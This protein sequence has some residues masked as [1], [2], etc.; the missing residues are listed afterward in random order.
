M[1]KSLDLFWAGTASHAKNEQWFWEVDC[2][3]FRHSAH[4]SFDPR[5]GFNHGRRGRRQRFSTKPR[6]LWEQRMS[7]LNMWASTE[8]WECVSNGHSRHSTRKVNGVTVWPVRHGL[9]QLEIIYSHAGVGFLSVLFT[10]CWYSQSGV[11]RPCATTSAC[12]LSVSGQGKRTDYR[13]QHHL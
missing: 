6:S 10:L 9:L 4:F 3:P 13:F 8:M 2:C 1:A 12:I 11:H 5:L 7:V